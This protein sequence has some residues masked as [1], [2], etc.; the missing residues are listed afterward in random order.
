MQ[1]AGQKSV[2]DVSDVVVIDVFLLTLKIFNLLK[3]ARLHYSGDRR[4]LVPE[5]RLQPLQL[6]RFQLHPWYVASAP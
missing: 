2:F 5:G 6:Q 3:H 4:C 1:P